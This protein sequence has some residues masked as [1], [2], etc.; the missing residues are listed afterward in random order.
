L[1]GTKK[2]GRGD[3]KKNPRKQGSGVRG[4]EG[5]GEE[6]VKEDRVHAKNKE[7]PGRENLSE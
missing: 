7:S 5:R 3:I 1:G 6:Q 4:G 2:K